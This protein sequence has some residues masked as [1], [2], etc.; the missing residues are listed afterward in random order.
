M[1]SCQS[2]SEF[3]GNKIKIIGRIKKIACNRK[4]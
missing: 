2:A 4:V 1:R 3:K